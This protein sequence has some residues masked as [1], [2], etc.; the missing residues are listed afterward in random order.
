MAAHR[1][2]AARMAHWAYSAAL[3]ARADVIGVAVGFRRRD[4]ELTDQH[5]L[6]VYVQRKLPLDQLRPEDRLPAALTIDGAEVELDVE[7]IETPTVP[8]RARQLTIPRPAVPHL[9]TQRRPLAGGYSIAHFNF[10]VGTVALGVLDLLHGYR[11]AL[12]CNH[13]LARMNAGIAGDAALQP[14]QVD[15]GVF[16]DQ[17]VGGLLRFVPVLFDG[18]ANRVD[19]AIAA[20]RAGDVANHVHGIGP[21]TG[22]AETGEIAPGDRVTKVGRSSGL[23]QGSVLVTNM[24]VKPDY[25]SLGYADQTALF[26]DQ[27]VVD[28]PAAVGDSGSLLLDDRQR[29]VGMLFG[30]LHHSWFNP[31]SAIRDELGIGLLPPTHVWV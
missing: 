30:G 5:V 11:C 15:G 4:G 12:S 10:P 27:I 31:F 13:V 24:T 25:V 28:I 19:A 29:A 20:C 18:R 2:Y 17:A 26:V 9:A 8:P 1:L 6:K 23:T 16:P 3:I 7:E 22:I 14:A 21:V